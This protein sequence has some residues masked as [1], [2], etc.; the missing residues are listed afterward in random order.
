MFLSIRKYSG[1]TSPDEVTKRVEEGLVPLLKST[2]GFIAY[3]ATK[4]ENGDLGGVSVF[5]SKEHSDNALEQTMSW[6]KENLSELL[7]NAP[8]VMRGEVLIHEM[9]QSMGKTA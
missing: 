4:F 8:E 5:E 9:T 7:P 2:S 3:Y 6:V 1:A